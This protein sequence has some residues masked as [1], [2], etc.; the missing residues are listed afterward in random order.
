MDIYHASDIAK[1]NLH[2]SSEVAIAGNGGTAQDV[3]FTLSKVY[4]KQDVEYDIKS[5]NNGF[6]Y[7]KI[8]EQ[9]GLNDTRYIFDDETFRSTE[10]YFNINSLTSNIEIPNWEV[11]GTIFSPSNIINT[12][13]NVGFSNNISFGLFTDEYIVNYISNPSNMVSSNIIENY[14]LSSV[15]DFTYTITEAIEGGSLIK[16]SVINEGIYNIFLVSEDFKSNYKIFHINTAGEVPIPDTDKFVSFD[17]PYPSSTIYYYNRVYCY[18]YNDFNFIKIRGYDNSGIWVPKLF[19]VSN[20]GTEIASYVFT[21][22][23]SNINKSFKIAI[24]SQNTFVVSIT[25]GGS[26]DLYV[27]RHNGSVITMLYSTLF[28]TLVTSPNVNNHS[29]HCLVE[30]YNIPNMFGIMCQ[31]NWQQSHYF[32]MKFEQNALSVVNNTTI[33]IDSS[34]YWHGNS[35]N[36][37]IAFSG[38]GSFYG[39][40]EGDYTNH[41]GSF[42]LMK[43]IEDSNSFNYIGNINQGGGEVGYIMGYFFIPEHNLFFQCYYQ[44]MH[45][46]LGNIYIKSNILG[47]TN[48]TY[49]SQL[50]IGNENTYW[51]SLQNNRAYESGVFFKIHDGLLNNTFMMGGIRGGSARFW[52]MKYNITTGVM[53]KATDLVV[54]VGTGATTIMTSHNMKFIILTTI[55]TTTFDGIT[56]K[57][58]NVDDIINPL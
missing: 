35:L 42:K 25:N 38:M 52:K 13:Y 31:Q 27:L 3:T 34:R 54:S 5:I 46:H 41:N 2:A 29:A 55:N 57:Y 39:G 45:H 51:V 17:T 47:E 4:T 30:Y 49:K 32:I 7:V 20:Y 18:H 6:L 12:V 10:T 28:T 50:T 16:T 23:T 14:E 56:Y 58:I 43:Y 15:H 11:S 9:S 22:Y 53:T 21:Q 8:K 40:I 19:I 44:R 36:T 24:I 48:I 1:I 26:F 33:T 37:S